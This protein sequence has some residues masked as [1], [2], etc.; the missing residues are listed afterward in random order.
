MSAR[1]GGHSHIGIVALK[2]VTIVPVMDFHYSS[3]PLPSL[4]RRVDSHP[5]IA[6]SRAYLDQR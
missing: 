2:I 4:P 3:L 5:W 6:G 1:F